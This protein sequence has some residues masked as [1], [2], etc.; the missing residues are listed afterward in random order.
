MAT[1]PVQNL[2]RPAVIRVSPLEGR[3]GAGWELLR[4]MPAWIISAGIHGLLLFLFYLVLQDQASLQATPPP[5]QQETFNTKVEEN[6]PADIPL[7]NVEEGLAPTVQTNYDEARISE[8]DVS[9][10]G[11]AD[12]SAAEGIAG[13]KEGP[14]VTVPAPPGS[15]TGQG[16]A[17]EMDLFGS[18]FTTREIA[19]GYFSGVRLVPGGFAGRSGATR[20]RIAHEYGG[21]P[22][23]EAAVGKGLLWLAEHQADNG[24][25][26]LS[27]FHLHY[28]P[29]LKAQKPMVDPRATGRGLSGAIGDTA[30]AAFGVLPFLAAGITHKPGSGKKAELD[31]RYVKT[32]DRALRYLMNKQGR[33][34]D[35][36]GNMYSHGLATIAICEAYGL[37]SDPNLKASA[38]RAIKFI[39]DAQ[40]PD[41]GG[42]RYQPRQGSDTSVVGW[43]VM[44]LKSGQMS[45][46]NVPN[47]TLRGAEKWLDACET[48]DKGSY[49]YVNPADSPTM[50]AVGLLCRQYLGTPRRNPGLRIGCDK[51][52]RNPPG[53]A[54]GLYYDYYATQVM[55]HMGGEYWDFWNEGPKKNKDGMRDILIKRQDTD[56]SWNPA[57]DAHG[58]SGGRIMVTSLSLLTLEV[59]Y[60]HLPLYQRVNTTKK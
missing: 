33:D 24:G 16:G 53:S 14:P 59:Y 57:N 34:G 45:G 1:A 31:D 8:H 47:I 42:W 50:S 30:G 52:K 13:E 5:R 44:A 19:G 9:V 36:G 28:R 43:Q 39:V 56:G 27:Q 2:S 22:A 3:N 12:P 26:S 7:T 46:L 55:H 41:S 11:P 15:G 29:G 32:V 60:R 23:S 49:G 4:T 25:W 38:Q 35:F 17:R 20:K 54:Y 6:N 48:S 51:L 37:T 58:T 10:P 18:G 40:D 21:S